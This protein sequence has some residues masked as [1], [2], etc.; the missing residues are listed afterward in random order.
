MK[1]TLTLVAALLV[2]LPALAQDPALKSGDAKKLAKAVG[3]WVAADID[4]DP[5]D[6]LDARDDIQ[7][8]M[9][10]INKKLKK[11]DNIF[12]YLG[13]W[14]AGLEGRAGK[15]PRAKGGNMDS[16]EHPDGS[17]VLA[18]RIADDYAPKKG[19]VPIILYFGDGGEVGEEQVKAL[20]EDIL[21]EF[22]VCAVNTHDLEEDQWLSEGRRRYLVAVAAL[23]QNLRLDRSRVYVLAGGEAAAPASLLVSL[24]PHVPA[25]VALFGDVA[26]GVV[27]GNLDLV[28]HEKVD[29]LVG[30]CAWIK[31]APG[32]ASYPTDFEFS[33]A[34]DKFG[35]CFWAQANRF[36]PPEDGKAAT[37]KIKADRATNTITIE[38]DRVYQVDLFL[39]DSL[40]DLSKPVTLIRNGQELQVQVTPG[41]GTLIE[42]YRAFMRD[43]SAI[44]PA[45]LRGIDIPVVEG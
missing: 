10:G 5:A 21:A 6:K 31:Q 24:A 27:P 22:V 16:F 33:L 4:G 45:R 37:L 28:P 43:T 39:N 9:D 19:G 25:G 13:D 40:V 8:A 26:S 12:R 11:D 14:S 35:R 7:K 42:N 38:A 23:S 34:E 32:R 36:D 41:L 29:D 20:P 15:F 1:A 18:Y 3:T 44:Y 30:A 2:A 17:M